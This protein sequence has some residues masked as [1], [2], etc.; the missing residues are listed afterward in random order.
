MELRSC[1]EEGIA[2]LRSRP[3]L[4]LDRKAVELAFDGAEED[5]TC[6]TCWLLSGE[7]WRGWREFWRLA[8]TK[9]RR[10]SVDGLGLTCGLLEAPSLSFDLRLTF[11]KPR[12]S[13]LEGL[14]LTGGLLE[15]PSLSFDL[16]LA[17]TKPRRSSIEGLGLTS[18]SSL[19]FVFSG[20]GTVAAGVA[21]Y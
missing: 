20:G 12:R 1:W 16:R 15:A 6:V 19:L 14:G 13:S 9:P 7:L 21:G 11:T 8:C 10:S 18:G 2:A 5:I 4:F 3:W 17:F